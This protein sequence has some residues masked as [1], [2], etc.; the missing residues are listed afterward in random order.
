MTHAHEHKLEF[1][2]TEV[3][4]EVCVEEELE[5]ASITC[6]KPHEHHTPSQ[7]LVWDCHLPVAMRTHV[8]IKAMMIPVRALRYRHTDIHMNHS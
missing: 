2:L 7:P 1:K 8:E 3:N 6:M 4:Q 5:L